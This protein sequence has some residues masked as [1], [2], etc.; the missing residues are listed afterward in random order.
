MSR[1]KLILLSSF[2]YQPRPDDTEGFQFDSSL[3]SF[4]PF[5]KKDHAENF[6]FS[7]LNFCQNMQG[8]CNKTKSKLKDGPKTVLIRSDFFFDHFTFFNIIQFN[9]C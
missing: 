1:E 2:S 5:G 7:R 8:K 9:L 6:M 3:V 4:Q